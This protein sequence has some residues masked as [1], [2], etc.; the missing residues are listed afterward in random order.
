[1][2]IKVLSRMTI[3]EKFQRKNRTSVK[4]RP[5]FFWTFVLFFLCGSSTL[6]ASSASAGVIHSEIQLVLPKS[7]ISQYAKA[8]KGHIQFQK[9]SLTLSGEF[10]LELKN[11]T[12]GFSYQIDELFPLAGGHF[13]TRLTLPAVDVR[14]D[15]MKIDTVIEIEKGGV[16]ARI[17]L[18]ALCRGVRVQNQM[19]LQ[20]SLRSLVKDQPQLSL[21][22]TA[23][24]WPRKGGVWNLTTESCEA[25]PGFTEFMNE[26]LAR[27]WIES[28]DL[29]GYFLKDINNEVAT[30]WAQGLQAQHAI[31]SLQT[32]LSLK[33]RHFSDTASAWVFG[34]E[35]S[36]D[37]NLRSNEI[38]PA[39]SSDVYALN[40]TADQAESNKTELWISE[41]VLETWAR[42]LHQH[43]LLGRE[44]RGQ[45]MAGFRQLMNSRFL[46]FFVWP[47]LMRFAKTTDFHF[48]TATYGDFKLAPVN[49]GKDSSKN[50]VDYKLNT[51]IASRMLRP[52]Q[53]KWDKYMTFFSP[54]QT[55]LRMSIENSELKIKMM[56]DLSTQLQYRFDI[57]KNQIRYSKV[58][59]GRIEKEVKGVLV[60]AGYQVG[61]PQIDIAK[62]LKFKAVGLTRANQTLKM[63]LQVVGP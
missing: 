36:V 57:P 34:I 31:E 28:T 52:Q 62:N 46:Q 20:F 40:P 2:N 3:N 38:C 19:P 55:G 47:D 23:L 41:S 61:L 59:V 6:L 12:V 29:P 48:F 44:D 10:P 50:A 7:Q 37:A 32:L 21:L 4:L 54:L 56:G 63:E 35:L 49:G 18:R 25:A 42:C 1:M 26:Q 13:E 58:G 39:L 15:E 51:M 14:I 53:G 16:R 27:L 33:G 30:W 11:I 43:G 5:G 24:D 60:D 17:P 8:Q 9:E 45:E 22:M